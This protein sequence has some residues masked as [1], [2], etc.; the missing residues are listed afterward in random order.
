[1]GLDTYREQLFQKLTACRDENHC[2]SLVDEADSVL[3][4]SKIGRDDQIRF[5]RALKDDLGGAKQDAAPDALAFR[6]FAATQ[7][8]IARQEAIIG[9][10]GEGS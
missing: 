4:G 8:A 2:R 3:Q 10:G 6:V 5:W 9:R 1:V 7:A